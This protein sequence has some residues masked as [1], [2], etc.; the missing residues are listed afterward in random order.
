MSDFS[1]VPGKIKRFKCL[2]KLSNQYVYVIQRTGRQEQE[3]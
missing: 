1:S 2:Q 3:R